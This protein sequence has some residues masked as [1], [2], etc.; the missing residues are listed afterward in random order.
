MHPATPLISTIWSSTKLWKKKKPSP[1]STAGRGKQGPQMAGYHGRLHP[2]DCLVLQL[3]PVAKAKDSL[4]V[5]QANVCPQSWGGLWISQLS[6]GG[7]IF[8]STEL[9]LPILLW[10]RVLLSGQS[11]CVKRGRKLSGSHGN[12]F[13]LARLTGSFETRSL[14]LLRGRW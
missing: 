13:H 9:T 14:H 1:A 10:N 3:V 4:R 6:F 2:V 7:Q 12:L 5:L 11:G 8:E